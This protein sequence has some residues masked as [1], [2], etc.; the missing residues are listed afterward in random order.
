MKTKRR[1]KNTILMKNPLKIILITD[2]LTSGGAERVMSI[3]ANNFSDI[4]YNT[5]II[6]KSHQPAFYQLNEKIKLVF[7]KTKINY[8]NKITTLFSRIHLYRDIY[9][10]LKNENPEL[11]IPFSTT[12]NG[13]IILL[14]KM[15]GLHVIA[16]EHTN[17]KVKSI[18]R[19]FI[20]RYI[21][22]HANFLTVLTERDKKEYYDR[23]MNNVI[24]MPNPLPLAPI[25]NVNISQREK[26]IL[27]VGNLSRWKI[28]GFDNLLK[29]F[30]TVTNKYS[31]W[32]LHI[33]G[34]G[35]PMYLQTLIKDLKLENRV[36]ILGEIKDIQ[37]LMQQSAIFVLPSR[38]E[39]LPMVLL[40][41]MSQGMACIAFDCFTG[42]ADILTHG[43]DGIIIEDQN[44][45]NFAKELSKLIMDEDLRYTLGKNA[46]ETSKTYLPEKIVTRWQFLIEQT[47]RH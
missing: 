25:E 38:W 28:K 11:V 30:S 5:T 14:C 44:N 16:S 43:K 32:K 13:A 31:D 27:A 46:I 35:D 34:G 7:P 2:S 37:S 10:Y 9:K 26:I 23:F 12:T 3:L 18:F 17:Y 4:G 1:I 20:K 29:I 39:G 15:L 40:E 45:T 33:A 36:T 8:Q 41:A 47:T 6:S 19:W 21:Y 24:V 22:P 42:P